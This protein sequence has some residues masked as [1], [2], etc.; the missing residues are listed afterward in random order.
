LL[1]ELAGIL[2]VATGEDDRWAAGIAPATLLE[3][4]LQLDSL[5]LATVATLLRQRFGDRVDLAGFVAGL[6][7]DELIGLRV[8]DVL[9]YL[10][11]RSAGR[12]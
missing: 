7:I 1:A 9:A 10:S 4:D 3:D 6:G 8:G 11:P 5:E 2:R 12:R